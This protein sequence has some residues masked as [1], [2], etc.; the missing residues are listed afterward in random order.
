MWGKGWVLLQ[1]GKWETA[2]V[3]SGGGGGGEG[4]LTLRKLMRPIHII[5]P[6]DDR[7]QLEA[8]RVRIDVHLRRRLARGVRI[9]R[10]Q[11]AILQQVRVALADLAVDLV[12]RDVDEAPDAR[13]DRALDHDV[14]AVHVRLGELERVAEAQVDVGLRREVEDRVDLVRGEAAHHVLD[15]GHVAVVEG[16]VGLGVEDARVVQGRAIVELVEGDDVVGRVGEG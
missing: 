15:L 10:R 13:L 7:R 14:R 4:E 16:E 12:G 8:L 1:D 6:H 11:Q 9:R 5:A 3:R 2:G